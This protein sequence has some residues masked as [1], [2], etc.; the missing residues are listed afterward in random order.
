MHVYPIINQ[1]REY[2]FM[3]IQLRMLFFVVLF[4]VCGQYGASAAE[5]ILERSEVSSDVQNDCRRESFTLGSQL[6][7]R[8]VR[9]R[10][11]LPPEYDANPE[12]S[13][14]IL[15]AQHGRGAP[16]ATFSEMSPLRRALATKPMI[17]VMF[18]AAY[19]SFYVDAVGDGMADRSVLYV[20]PRKTKKLTEEAYVEKLAAWEARP[21]KLL[22]KYESFFFNEYVPTIDSLYRVQTEKRAI[23]GFSMGG[24]GAMHF[25][26]LRPDFFTSVSGLSAAFY[27]AETIV[28][29]TE[30]GK[31][32]FEKTLGVYSADNQ[33]YAKV[34]HKDIIKQYANDAVRLPPIYEYCGTE[35]FLLSANQAMAAQLKE[36]GF[37][38]TYKEGPGKHDWKFWVGASASVIDFHWQHFNQ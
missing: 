4:L 24:F 12:K 28:A 23:T 10:V 22:V 26:L 9:V 32:N 31:N 15:Y 1:S 18:D 27:D 30:K 11:V 16:Y 19:A 3:G 21:E 5:T 6:L 2:S 37:A 8:D 13:Y 36:S 34:F 17:V 14:P 33:A 35:D 25:C 38:I 29:A 20:K 7:Q